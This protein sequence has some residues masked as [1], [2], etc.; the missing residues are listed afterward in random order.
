[1]HITPE[2]K[3]FIGVASGPNWEYEGRWRNSAIGCEGERFGWRNITH[4]LVE[5]GLAKDDALDIRKRLI[6]AGANACLNKRTVMKT[7]VKP[8]ILNNSKKMKEKQTALM[9]STVNGVKLS[10]T[11]DNRY[12]SKSGYPVVVRVYKD[13]K[14]AYVPTGF[15]MSASDF[16]KCCGDT[17]ATLEEKYDA[18]KRW[19][20]ESL[21]DGTFSVGGARNCLKEKKVCDTLADFITAKRK[22][23][24]GKG[25]AINYSSALKWVMTVFPDGLPADR[26]T[27]DSINLITA[28][29]KEDGKTDTTINVYLSVIKAS[30][31]YAIYKGLFDDRRY[32]FKKNAWEC[33]KV[34]IPKSAKR[35]DRWIGRDEIRAVWNEFAAGADK[36]KNKWMG[37]FLFSYLTGGMNLADMVGLKFTKEWINRGVIRWV[38]RK[39]AHKNGDPVAVPVCG[40]L[41]ELLS[42][43]GITPVEGE[44]VFP[45]LSGDYD[46]V[47][48]NAAES[49][50]RV[51]S[52]YG[53]SMTY[54]RHS[55][56]TNMNRM[57]AP[58]SMTEAAMGHSLGGVSSHYIAPYQ[59]E[60]MLPWFEKL[61]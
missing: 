14:W 42:V 58:F 15:S 56:C 11:F 1:M 46:R 60:D 27:P 13:R 22:T 20:L 59:P 2:L 32:P 12:K 3:T 24:S 41:N 26:I 37:M 36:K 30:I 47:K 9:T 35:Q 57:G 40:K 19:C 33:D 4:V 53:V 23:V 17:L 54:A 48:A 52:G 28:A 6:N 38:R 51:M 16:R 44:P 61:L 29:L 18:V 43:M 49:I 31:N 21:S 50:N 55:F 7:D 34:V 45:F 25:T 5:D 39:T 10:L 8:N